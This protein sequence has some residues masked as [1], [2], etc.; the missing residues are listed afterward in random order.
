MEFNFI[1]ATIKAFVKVILNDFKIIIY[2][3]VNS[4]FF[5]A[6]IFIYIYIRFIWWSKFCDY[7]NLIVWWGNSGIK[8]KKK[9]FN[10][11]CQIEIHFVTSSGRWE[12]V[13]SPTIILCDL[14]LF[15]LKNHC[16]TYSKI[17][18]FYEKKN[19]KTKEID[20]NE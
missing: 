15:K 10:Q 3:V 5:I 9:V 7:T 19:K 17:I 20:W 2:I 16:V 6:I 13:L 1:I 12:F 8:V 18:F 4:R 11:Y 14:L